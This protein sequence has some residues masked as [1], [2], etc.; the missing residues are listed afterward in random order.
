MMISKIVWNSNRNDVPK[1][2]T[3][4][5]VIVYDERLAFFIKDD[6]LTCGNKFKKNANGSPTP[7]GIESV[8]AL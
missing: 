4:E 3:T 5:G 1:K 8:L 2:K 6:V 7:L